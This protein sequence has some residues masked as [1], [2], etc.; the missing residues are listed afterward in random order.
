MSESFHH[1][2]QYISGVNIGRLMIFSCDVNKIAGSNFMARTMI[3]Y[4]LS[5]ILPSVLYTRLSWGDAFFP[6]I[7]I[8]LLSA[9]TLAFVF[10]LPA[11][12]VIFRREIYNLYVSGTVSFAVL[13]VTFSVFFLL[14]GS[15]YENLISH[16]EVLVKDGNLSLDGYR[17]VLAGA[18]VIALHGIFGCLLFSAFVRGRKL[19]SSSYLAW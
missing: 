6:M 16:G 4:V 7:Y 12:V 5:P 19:F 18:F 17:R 15:G 8:V 10:L 9:Y 3:G 2:E 13:L 1:P 11:H 14:S